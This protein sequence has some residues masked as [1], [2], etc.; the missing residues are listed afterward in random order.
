M[1]KILLT[2]YASNYQGRLFNFLQQAS[3]SSFLAISIA[4][5]VIQFNI[6]IQNLIITPHDLIS[7]PL[8][9]IPSQL[10]HFTLIFPQT[11]MGILDR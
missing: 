8:T 1:Y 5:H 2:V 3:F 10:N 7:L 11:I 9:H 6:Y 4:I